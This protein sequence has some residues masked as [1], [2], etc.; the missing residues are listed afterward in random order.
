VSK[1]RAIK[2]KTIA[3]HTAAMT[4]NRRV[5]NGTSGHGFPVNRLIMSHPSDWV[6]MAAYMAAVINVFMCF[7]LWFNVV[8]FDHFKNRPP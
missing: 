5:P 4:R 6:T 3:L 8:K 7:L 1:Y 2:N